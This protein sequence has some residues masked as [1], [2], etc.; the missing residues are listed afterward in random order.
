MTEIEK[1]S[2]ELVEYGVPDELIGK[3]ENLLANLYSENQ[4]LRIANSWSVSPAVEF[5]E[6]QLHKIQGGRK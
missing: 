2:E 1:I 6:S 5:N 3:I 4:K